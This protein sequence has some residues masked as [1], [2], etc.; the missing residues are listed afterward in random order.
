LKAVW[1]KKDDS[2]KLQEKSSVP[3]TSEI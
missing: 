2:A 1:K 3:S